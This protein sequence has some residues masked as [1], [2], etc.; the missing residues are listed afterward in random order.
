MRLQIDLAEAKKLDE[1]LVRGDC[2][3]ARALLARLV[4]QQRAR[5]VY[6]ARVGYVLK[7]WQLAR[8]QHN[9]AAAAVLLKLYQNLRKEY[10]IRG[11]GE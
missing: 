11:Y 6:G 5:R 4:E 3:G 10:R 9:H 7:A 8:A 2:A 1:L